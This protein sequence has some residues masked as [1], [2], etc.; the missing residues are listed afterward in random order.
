M[1]GGGVVCGC[2]FFFVSEPE[3]GK[4]SSSQ[5]A[6]FTK[7]S[8]DWKPDTLGS[9]LLPSNPIMD[10]VNE[11]T[12]VYR[13]D[14]AVNPGTTVVARF[15]SGI[16]L[17][18]YKDVGEGRIIG[19][20]ADYKL[21]PYFTNEGDFMQLYRNATLFSVPEPATILILGLGAAILRRR[22]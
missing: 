10:G 2:A 21:N 5:Y 17:A 1:S 3:F 19:I 6:P 7:G 14:G 4:L 16:P 15:K 18:G 11:L 22:K 13:Y 12:T 8:T 9:I 20:Q